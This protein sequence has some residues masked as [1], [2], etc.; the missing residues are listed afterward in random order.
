MR[1]KEIFPTIQGE[2]HYAGTP[3]LFVRFAGCNLWSGREEHRERDAARNGVSCPRFC[4][5][6]FVGGDEM[7]EEELV[8]AL[9]KEFKR[10]NPP[11]VVFTGGEPLLQLTA[12]FF[13]LLT[14]D[15]LL[16]PDMMVETNGTV[17]LDNS[18]ALSLD[19]VCVSPKSPPDQLKV[20][21]GDE[22]K[23]VIPA[24]DPKKYEHL[25]FQVMSVQ[26]EAPTTGLAS[27][28]NV[29]RAVRFCLENPGWKLSLQQHKIMR[30]P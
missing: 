14:R 26:P 27:Q 6:D 5:T 30:I 7:S 15:L 23:V 11:L 2:G 29:D 8:D 10:W 18:V 28:D 13:R 9:R 21:R 20:T 16:R 19:W 12:N 4:D 17:A 25:S 1:V 24:Y 22:L 3:A